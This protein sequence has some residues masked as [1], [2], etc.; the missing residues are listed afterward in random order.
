MAR[1]MTTGT[2]A[3]LLMGAAFLLL[4][5]ADAS[6]YDY[7]G[8]FDKCL[9]FFEAQRSGKLP[10]DRRVKWRG[11]SALTDG[12]SQGV[13]RAAP[14]AVPI[15]HT[16]HAFSFKGSECVDHGGACVDRWIWWAGTTTRATTS[17]SGSPWRTR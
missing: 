9:Q 13:R 5:A 10:A 6:P 12:F 3:A 15:D 4:A 16:L 8:A 1:L 2:S 14:L 11:D 17:S 7:A